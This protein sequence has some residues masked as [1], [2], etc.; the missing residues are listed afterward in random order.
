MIAL[1]PDNT[2]P[3]GR[4]ETQE[5]EEAHKREIAVDRVLL[6]LDC[7][8]REIRELTV[9]LHQHRGDAFAALPKPIIVLSTA[10]KIHDRLIGEEARIIAQREAAHYAEWV[11]TGIYPQP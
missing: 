4:K 10:Q 7:L 3:E 8:T 1:I 2:T 5:W 6:D 11:A 9:Y